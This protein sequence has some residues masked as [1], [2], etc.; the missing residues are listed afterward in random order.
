VTPPARLATARAR[1]EALPP[2]LYALA[3]VFIL[4]ALVAPR[5]ASGGNLTNVARVA[6]IL[7]LAAFGQAVVLVTGGIDFSS[8]SSVALTSVVSV[9]LVPSLGPSA[10]LAVGCLAAVAIGAANG[11][12]V[13]WL[14]LPPFLVTLGM[15]IAVHGLASLLVGGVPLEAPASLGLSPLGRGTVGGIPLPILAAAAGFV[16]LLVL[17]RHTALGRTWYLVGSNVRAARMA[18]L[19]VRRSLWLAYAVSGAFV[20]AAGLV[21]TARVSS[22]QPNLY[23]SLP[24]EA[25]AACAIGGVP[26]TGGAG[27]PAQVLAG[28]LIVA[29]IQN[30]AV[31]LN[32]PSSVQLVLIGG[33]TVGA[34]LV[35]QGAARRVGHA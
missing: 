15:L 20:A 18:G 28:V 17:L 35:Q 12:L 16:V 19:D 8:G 25:I 3:L 6:A 7:G 13:A 26:L 30:A 21:L 5:F 14:E 2:S 23:P 32:F 29:M 27:T 9:L 22:G 10:S 31:L 1:L 11:L 24:F 4:L 33:L 34:V